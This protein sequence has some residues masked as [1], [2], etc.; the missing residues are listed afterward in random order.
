MESNV[1]EAE[2]TFVQILCKKC[3][4]LWT[5][6]WV[7]NKVDTSRMQAAEMRMSRMRCGK[8]LRDGIPKWLAE[9]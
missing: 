1:I 8:T 5:E 2:R 7:T 6:C 3:D 9:R 4:E